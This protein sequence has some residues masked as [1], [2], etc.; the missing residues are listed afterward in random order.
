VFRFAGFELDLPRA[1]LRGPDGGAIKLRPKAFEMLRLFASSAGRV[2]DKGE[3]LEAIWPRV[4]VGDDSLFQCIRELR[5]ALDDDRRQMI[6]LVSGRGY[7]FAVEVSMVLVDV[8]AH[9]KTALSTQDAKV[10][11]PAN[12]GSAAEPAKPERHRRGTPTIAVMPLVAT[13]NDQ[14]GAALATGAT[15]RLI[16]GLARIDSIRVVAPRPSVT[17]DLSEPAFWPNSDFVVQGELQRGEQSWVLHARIIKTV[18]GEIRSFADVSININEPDTQLQHMRLAAG[19]GHPLALHLNALQEIGED[20]AASGGDRPASAAKIIIE[21]ALASNSQ[22]SRERFAIAQT[23]LENAIA[24]EPDNLDLKLALATLQLRGIQM[25]WYGPAEHASIENAI[26]SIRSLLEPA[27]R[28]KPDYI[29]VLDAYSRF[30]NTTNQFVENLITCA[31]TLSFDPW[32]GVALYHL[33]LAQLQ[34]GRFE[35][36]LA[37][38]DRAYRF[39]TPAASR[40]TWPLGAG[41]ACTLMGRYEDALPWLQR[42][43]AITSASGRTHML[44]AAIYQ[45]LGRTGEAKAAMEKGLE[46]RPGSTARNVPLPREN[47]SPVF[48][49]ASDRITLLMVA[50]G[51]PEG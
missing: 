3:L 33:G 23:M 22:T 19:I 14:R 18:T 43:L 45:Q 49:Q 16:D 51:L 4:N 35:D 21:Q 48:L 34:L 26:K 8:S 7:M 46:L 27:L 44:L 42:S 36:A 15:D 9:T 10:Q 24:S 47:T 1:E 28:A 41:W 31:R 32:N 6:K 38:F 37:T 20:Q 39:D 5:A 11:P 40:W 17:R 30:L 29:P 50:A 12:V 25:V 13:S 2:L